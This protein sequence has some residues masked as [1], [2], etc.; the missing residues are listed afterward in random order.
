ML[1]LF[2]VSHKVF[3]LHLLAVVKVPA[4]FAASLASLPRTTR[5]GGTR[6]FPLN[7][8]PLFA[9]S[10]SSALVW[11]D[12]L[13]G[14]VMRFLFLLLLLL[15]GSRLPC[16]HCCWYSCFV[17]RCGGWRRRLEKHKHRAAEADGCAVFVQVGQQLKAHLHARP[18]DK[19][20]ILNYVYLKNMSP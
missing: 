7:I 19:A 6:L 20:S 4:R 9:R 11:L 3:S 2:R 1:F 15:L 8:T 10:V 18:T 5:T 14:R 12:I 13:P 16:Q 17:F